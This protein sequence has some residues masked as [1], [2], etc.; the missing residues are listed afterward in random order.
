MEYNPFVQFE[1]VPECVVLLTMEL[2]ILLCYHVGLP[3]FGR[4]SPHRIEKRLQNRI[5]IFI[6]NDEYSGNRRGCLE[7]FLLFYYFCSSL[8]LLLHNNACDVINNHTADCIKH[9]LTCKYYL[10]VFSL[11]VGES[12]A[13]YGFYGPPSASPASGEG[14]HFQNK[15]QC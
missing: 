1:L 10:V 13:K 11:G 5:E 2:P 4:S 7:T 6:G 3:L 9:N 14:W 15:S 12:P 8:L